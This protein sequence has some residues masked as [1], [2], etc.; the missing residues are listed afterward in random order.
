MST[1]KTTAKKTTKKAA[2]ERVDFTQHSKFDLH[3]K[4]QMQAN[5]LIEHIEVMKNTSG[6]LLMKQ[7]LEGNMAVLEEAI[8]TKVD[9]LSNEKLSN[10]EVDDARMKR[11]YLKELVEKPDA[12]IA[13]FKK[14][15]GME[16]PTYDPYATE[17][18]QLRGNGAEVGAP[19]A[20]VL[21][22]E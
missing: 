14:Q 19:M 2:K 4:N 18:K 20:R 5:E 7:I 15:G 11:G 8:I 16:V 3:I 1:K 21:S 13:M 9:P 12:L 22:D 6:W 17:S 10:E